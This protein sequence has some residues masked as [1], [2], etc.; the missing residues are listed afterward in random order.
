MRARARPTRAAAQDH[1][2]LVSLGCFCGPKLSFKHIG[3]G[4]ETLPFDW[5]R[6]CGAAL[7]KFM[8]NDFEGAQARTH[9]AP[10]LVLAGL[11]VVW[12]FP[13]TRR[14]L[15]TFLMRG[16]PAGFVDFVFLFVRMFPQHG[17]GRQLRKSGFLEDV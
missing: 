13:K 10:H 12:P 15:P 16:L 11:A 9:K 2:T 4:A 6:T 3:R 17:F 5:M 1:I 7:L 8:R 14:F